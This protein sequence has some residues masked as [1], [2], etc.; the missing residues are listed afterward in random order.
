MDNENTVPGFKYECGKIFNIVAK[1][2]YTCIKTNKKR[3]K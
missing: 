3:K 2:K 1:I